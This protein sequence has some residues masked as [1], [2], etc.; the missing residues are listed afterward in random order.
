MDPNFA[1]QGLRD[2]TA[3]D[4]GGDL[5]WLSPAMVEAAAESLNFDD[6]LLEEYATA[7]D[8]DHQKVVE[9]L[10]QAGNDEVDGTEISEIQA[11]ALIGIGQSAEESSMVELPETLQITRPRGLVHPTAAHQEG[12]GWFDSAIVA[13]RFDFSSNLAHPKRKTNWVKRRPAEHRKLQPGNQW[14]AQV[15]DYREK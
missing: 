8:I 10:W 1:S 9:D 3:S 11:R 2:R 12:Y 4:V 15:A 5:S 7:V 13:S 6:D 14:Y